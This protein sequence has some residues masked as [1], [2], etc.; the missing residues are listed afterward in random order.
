MR[1]E[2]ETRALNARIEKLTQLLEGVNHE[3]SML[4]EQV[5]LSWC[6]A[7]LC[8]VVLC[9]LLQNVLIDR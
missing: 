8:C 9:L 2:E 4:L 5:G 3:Y 6:C 1:S 7:V